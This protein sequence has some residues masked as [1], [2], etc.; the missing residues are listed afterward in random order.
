MLLRRRT[1]WSPDGNSIVFGYPGGRTEPPGLPGIRLVDLRSGQVSDLTGSEG[2]F[3]PRWSPTGRYIAAL[4]SDMQRLLIFDFTGNKWA[5]LAK[6]PANSASWSRDG[7][8]IYFDVLSTGMPGVFRVRTS[9][10]KV[11]RV[12]SLKGLRR[13]WTFGLWAGLA[14]T[15]FHSSFATSAPRKSMEA[16]NQELTCPS[17]SSM[18]ASTGERATPPRRT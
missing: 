6:L 3:A 9:D 17:A 7:K 15:T 1:D 13:A 14:P 16:E 2:L 8:Y 12:L 10:H 4:P 18:M 5:E 11:E